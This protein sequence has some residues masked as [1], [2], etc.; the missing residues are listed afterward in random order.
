MVSITNPRI[1]IVDDEQMI[2]TLLLEIL[3]EQGYVCETAEN[4]GKALEILRNHAFDIALVDVKMPGL[5]GMDLLSAIH[6]SYKST[7]VIMITAVNDIS[8]AVEAIKNGASDYIIKPF[9]V[10]EIRSRIRLVLEDKAKYNEHSSDLS[11]N[12]EESE[13]NSSLRQ[14]MNFIFHNVENQV[15]LP[16][17]SPQ[18][19]TQRVIELAKQ[20]G[21]PEEAIKSW[22]KD[23][24]DVAQPEKAIPIHNEKAKSDEIL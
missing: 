4:T 10:D 16:E 15:E 23:R 6:K 7:S 12:V 18:L 19:V 11:K 21:L 1:L 17:I 22:V 13:T 3:G 5:S 24:R 14:L 8:T 9:R 2:C 20:L